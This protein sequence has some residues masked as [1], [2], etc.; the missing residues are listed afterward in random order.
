LPV[1]HHAWPVGAHACGRLQ[2]T[3]DEKGS[4]DRLVKALSVGSVDH[5][6]HQIGDQLPGLQAVQQLIGGQVGQGTEAVEGDVP[7]QFLPADSGEVGTG[8]AGDAGLVEGCG[9][10]LDPGANLSGKF[11]NTNRALVE[12]VNRSRV[13]AIAAEEGDATSW[14]LAQALRPIRTRS[15]EPISRLSR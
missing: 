2:H 5:F 4:F 3:L 9:E 6:L 14:S 7:D 10:L 8:L 1:D 15:T 12:V 11:S 13:A